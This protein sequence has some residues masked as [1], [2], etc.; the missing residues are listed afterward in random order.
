MS[1]IENLIPQNK[2]TKKEQREIAKKGGI[3]SGRKR[4]ERKKLKEELE[5][6]LSNGDYQEKMCLSLI[7]NA[8]N[9]N[10]KAFTII[11]DTLGE[12]DATVIDNR[13]STIL[14]DDIDPFKVLPIEELRKR[15]QEREKEDN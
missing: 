13:I 11:R 12:K 6:L 4:A 14:V 9:G 1:N 7:N 10:T 5:L 2:R 8:I 3:E 15:M